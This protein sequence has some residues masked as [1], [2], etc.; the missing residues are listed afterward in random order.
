MATVGAATPTAPG[1]PLVADPHPD[2]ARPVPHGHGPGRRRR[3]PGRRHGHR[4]VPGRHA[5]AGSTGGFTRDGY[6]NG[7]TVVDLTSGDTH[8][9]AA[10][11]RPLGIAV[12]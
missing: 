12:L 1:T 9:L 3:V 11:S 4:A 5:R 2:R 8:R 6:W 7:L 10:G